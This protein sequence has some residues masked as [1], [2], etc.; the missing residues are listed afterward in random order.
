MTGQKKSCF[1]Q[2]KWE[3]KTATLSL[4]LFEIRSDCDYM[5]KKDGASKDDDDD[6]IRRKLKEIKV[7]VEDFWVCLLQIIIR[8]I[9]IYLCIVRDIYIM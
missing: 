9:Y 6:G 2:I 7:L 3:K 5:A 1:S 8:F 4:H